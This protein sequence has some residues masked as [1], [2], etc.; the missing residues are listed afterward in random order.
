MRA[1][2]MND[3]VAILVASLTKAWLLG[4]QLF[5]FLLKQ[6]T[7]KPKTRNPKSKSYLSPQLTAML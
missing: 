3:Y 6:Q 2:N 1:T 4:L 5:D 7:L